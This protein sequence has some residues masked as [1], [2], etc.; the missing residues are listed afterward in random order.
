[1]KY[2]LTKEQ[3]ESFSDNLKK[4]I[5]KFWDQQ[6]KVDKKMTM[7]FFN[8]PY[9]VSNKLDEWALE[10]YGGE[11]KVLTI[12]RNISKKTL[13]GNAGT[14]NFKFRIYKPR[15]F[16]DLEIGLDALVDGSGEV[17]IENDDN[18]IWDNI[19][20]ATYDERISW[21]VFDEIR[22]II[23]ETIVEKTGLPFRM[24]VEDVDI[25]EKGQFPPN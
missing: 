14:Y 1:M 12:L 6:G 4:L 13:I 11:E 3:F 8:I 9:Q 5:T 16:D 18:E 23:Y 24:F 21:E 25:S 2:V 15:I 10:W 20:D 7:D 22:D 19:R 17:Y